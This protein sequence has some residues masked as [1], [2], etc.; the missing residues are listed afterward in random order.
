MGVFASLSLPPLSFFP[1]VFLITIP[2]FYLVNS[3]NLK[4][5]FL[6][7]FFLAF[8]WFLLSLYD[9]YIKDNVS[10]TAY[11]YAT[12]KDAIQSLIKNDKADYSDAFRDS[13]RVFANNF[14][15]KLSPKNTKYF[16]DK[17]PRYY[18]IINELARDFSD[19]KI[20]IKLLSVAILLSTYFQQSV[21]R[22]EEERNIETTGAHAASNTCTREVLVRGT[23][24]HVRTHV[25]AEK[26]CTPAQQRTRMPDPARH[27]HARR[28]P[29]RPRARRRA[30]TARMCHL[31]K[32]STMLRDTRE[33]LALQITTTI[34]T[35]VLHALCRCAAL[36]AGLIARCCC[37]TQPFASLAAAP[38]K[39]SC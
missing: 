15:N 7:G 12:T 34:D 5:A 16:L 20:I 26:A 18:Y 13:I 10:L 32:L 29:P 8:G 33:A 4:D 39:Q 36:C 1:I 9:A 38:A 37:S 14:Y 35:T 21:E 11:G 3:K 28:K 31:A 19:A 30:H 6:I 17:T 25:H 2:L 22:S 23:H 24:A 27:A